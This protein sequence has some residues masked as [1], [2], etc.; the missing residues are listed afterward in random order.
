VMVLMA[1]TRK[2]AMQQRTAAAMTA[3]RALLV[4]AKGM[5][6]GSEPRMK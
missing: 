4:Q 6:D 3:E 5:M 1:P 2:Q